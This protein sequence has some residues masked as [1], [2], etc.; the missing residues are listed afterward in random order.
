MPMP[1]AFHAPTDKIK[2]SKRDIRGQKDIA[3]LRWVASIFKV[4]LNVTNDSAFYKVVT[5]F[6]KFKSLLCC[7]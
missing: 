1:H 5:F 6:T 4:C 2:R 3:V 7:A